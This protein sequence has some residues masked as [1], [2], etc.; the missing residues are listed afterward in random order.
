MSDTD[1][2]SYTSEQAGGPVIEVIYPLNE[3]TEIPNTS[4]QLFKTVTTKGR[5]PNTQPPKG[6]KVTVH[7][8]GTLEADGSKFDSSRDRAEPF[9]FTIGQG[10]VIKGWDIGVATMEVG[11]IC[12]LKCL[13]EYAYGARGSPPTIPPSSTL[14]FE[15]ELISWTKSEDISNNK[16]G[17]VLKSVVTAGTGYQRPEYEAK[18]I[19][20]S[21]RVL[22]SELGDGEEPLPTPEED[23]LQE[24]HA[25]QGTGQLLLDVKDWAAVVGDLP[26]YWFPGLDE[27]LRSMKRGEHSYFSTSPGRI[28]EERAALAGESE[29]AVKDSDM[30]TK[31]LLPAAEAGKGLRFEI[32]LGDF[33]TVDIYSH[34]AADRVKE[35]LI[36]KADGNKYFMLKNWAKAEQKYRRALEFVDDE[37]IFGNNNN[38]EDDDNSCDKSIGE[39]AASCTIAVKS[40]L[41][42]VLINNNRLKEAL[43]LCNAVLVKDGSHLKTLFRRAKIYGLTEEWEMGISDLQRLLDMDAAN[44][45]A[46]QEMAFL[47]AKQ[48]AFYKKE[49]AKYANL[50]SKISSD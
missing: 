26:S 6:A 15:V 13:P 24:G 19:N 45:P 30:Y 14:L 42:Q 16:D 17:S 36:R 20:C 37:Y 44:A 9:E 32:S 1:T 39:E 49:K 28:A 27:A 46:M 48:A 38:N 47:K 43:D 12:I 4:A 22:L 35:G 31:V 34:S 10:Q 21:L 11:E 7:Y 40:N 41:A 2:A 29:E 25:A 8:T 5:K 18:L 3:E 50:F 33:E 23:C